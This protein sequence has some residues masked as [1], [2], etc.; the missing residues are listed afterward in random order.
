M[1]ARIS[2]SSSPIANKNNIKHSPSH[3]LP[4]LLPQTSLILTKIAINKLI[5]INTKCDYGCVVGRCLRFGVFCGKSSIRRLVLGWGLCNLPMSI[6]CSVSLWLTHRCQIL[7]RYGWIDRARTLWGLFVLIARVSRFT[8]YRP[9]FWYFTAD[10]NSILID[11]RHWT[12]TSKPSRTTAIL[13]RVGYL[14]Q[15]FNISTESISSA[16][17]RW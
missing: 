7:K 6:F 15:Y 9:I 10:I 4:H 12:V 17:A 14:L 11:T 16:S 13:P 2:I 5:S 3:T 1:G 8:G